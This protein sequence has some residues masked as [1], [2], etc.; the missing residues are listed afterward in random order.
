MFLSIYR[1]LQKHHESWPDTSTRR[2]VLRTAI[3]S[4]GGLLCLDHVRAASA[5]ADLPHVIVV[6]AGFAGLA[7][8]YELASTG[9]RV[10]VLEARHRVGGRVLTFHDLI[11]GKTIEGGGEL[12]GPNQPTWMAYAK[13]FGLRFTELPWNPSDVVSIWGK[14]LP[15]STAV[16]IWKEMRSALEQINAVA[17][18]IVDANR[19]WESPN[20]KEL[21]ARSLDDWIRQLDVDPRCRELIEIQMTGINGL[22]PAWQSWL[23]ILAIVRGGG[24]QKFWDETDTLHCVGGTQQLAGRLKNSFVN[25]S[26]D[27]RLQLGCP[28]HAIRI[29]DDRVF[30]KLHDGETLEADDVVL[31]VP[32]STWNKIAFDPTLP[33]QLTVP[34]AA[35]TKYLAVFDKPIWR[36]QDRQPNAMSS[37]PIQLTWETTAGQGDAGPHGLVAFAGGRAADECRGWPDS[38]RDDRCRAALDRL[39]PGATKE[40]VASRFVDWVSDPWARG[41]YS[42]P[43]P[44]QVTTVGPLLDRGHHGHLHFAGE[45]ACYAFVGWMEGALASGV[46]TAR[47]LAE[48]DG[49][50]ARVKDHSPQ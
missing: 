4:A 27:A 35:S 36:E 9:Y 6:G 25:S 30:V 18:N 22:I 41:T 50:V 16:R 42:F 10:T 44:G 46:R 28:V 26:G 32:P 11:K 31:T 7:C 39:Y 37:G 14:Q 34:L 3:A 33:P 48:R 1:Q 21:D 23:G 29:R 17:A 43:A 19:P 49:V 8:A 40:I 47:R 20:A 24:L 15:P 2:D 45:H 5:K 13:R 12:V 38:E